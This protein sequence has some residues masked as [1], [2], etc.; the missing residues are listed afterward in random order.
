MDKIIKLI[1]S[2]LKIKNDLQ[3]NGN[4]TLNTEKLEGCSKQRDTFKQ[5]QLILENMKE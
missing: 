5:K 2:I 1:I 4:K 3:V